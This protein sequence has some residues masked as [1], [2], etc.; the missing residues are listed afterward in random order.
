MI[1]VRSLVFYV[2]AIV[3]ALFFGLLAVLL[4]PLPAFPR[5]YLITRWTHFS[6]W[7]LEKCCHLRYRVTGRENIPKGP[8]VILANHQ[9][10]WE[11]LAFQ[12]IF[13]PHVWVLKR[14]LLRMPFFGWGLAALNPIAIRL[15]GGTRALRQ[16][17]TQGTERLQS[18]FWV[19]IFPEGMRVKPSESRDHAAGG[20]ALAK[21]A[22]C[23][24][25]LAAHNGGLFWPRRSM[26]KR[27]GVVDVVIGSTLEPPHKSARQIAEVA[28]QWIEKTSKGLLAAHLGAERGSPLDGERGAEQRA[29][30]QA[31]AD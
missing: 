1:W 17:L 10:A 23:P 6:L 18:G 21:H 11:T 26:L 30:S 7:W 27:A 31:A 4:R 29:A 25:V 19:L 16:V 9:S 15:N 24:V 20:A 22:G 5:Y 8:A 28:Q 2:G 12:A 13:P 14:N 3:A